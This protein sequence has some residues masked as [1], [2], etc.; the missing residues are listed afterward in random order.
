[1]SHPPIAILHDAQSQSWLRFRS[2]IAILTAHTPAQVLPLLNEIQQQVDRGLYAAG[3]V[4][5]EAAPAFDPALKTGATD[6]PLVWFGIYEQLETI[7]IPRFTSQSLQWLPGVSQ[8]QYRQAFDRIKA[9]IRQGDTYQ[10]NFSFRLNADFHQSPW[11]YFC[12]LIQVQNGR[13]GA[14]IETE[15]WA[16]C[17]ASPELFFR[18]DGQVIQCRPM[19]GTVARGMSFEG[20]RQLAQWLR[21]SAKNQAENVMIVDMIRNDLG[22][23]SQIGSVQV[24]SLFDIEQY[25]T[26]W[27][28]TSS[29]KGET[30]ANLSQIF[31]AM[32]P[33]A[34]ITGAPKKRTMEIIHELEETP[35]KIYTGT[36]GFI[37]PAR[38][39]QF[40]V[41]I[42]TVLID[43]VSQAAEYGVG[44]GIVWDSQ[45]GDEYEECCTKAKILTVAPPEFSLLESL[46]WTPEEGYF[47]LDLHLKR[48]AQSSAYFD[49]PLATP[50]GT[51][52]AL[53]AIQEQLLTLTATERQKVRL[54]VS[55]QGNVT[56]ESSPLIE[57]SHPLNV[58]LA[59]TPVDSSNVFLYHKTTHR[60]VYQ[61]AQAA[62]PGYDDVILWNEK[63]ELT[64]SCL[65]NLVVAIEGKHYT[66]PVSCGLLAGTFRS[67]LLQQGLIQERIIRVQELANA[68]VFL[69]N[70]VRQKRE[71][72][73]RVP[74]RLGEVLIGAENFS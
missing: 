11:H 34:S 74:N 40:N 57:T 12:H 41:A 46:L 39:A 73:V 50:P 58:C 7:D 70:S 35:R 54:L 59:P 9:Y 28:M 4:S 14:F 8:L 25:P 42:R 20:D 33:C 13:Y 67:W 43:K 23:I 5:Y 26:L 27:Q 24:S 64:E 2:P 55:Q 53:P 6:F 17:C 3:F 10:V 62:C 47:L 44:G 32:F 71:A 30:N 15:E 68:Q 36:I 37:T 45:A 56:I 63:G 49:I 38:T 72:I 48:L 16:I 61:Q 51:G 60:Q 66:P 21:N 65:A 31:Q 29:V 22:R 19:K 18:Q 69:I 52:I 1:M